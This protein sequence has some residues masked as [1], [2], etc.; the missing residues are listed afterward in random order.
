MISYTSNVLS[1]KGFLLLLNV[2]AS[3]LVPQISEKGEEKDIFP[4]EF[5]CEHAMSA[6][7]QHLSR[8]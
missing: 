7:V 6:S 4:T 5:N 3:L 2:I 1:V 8:L